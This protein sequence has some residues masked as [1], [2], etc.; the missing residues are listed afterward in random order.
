MMALKK[1]SDSLRRFLFYIICLNYSE[2]QHLQEDF[3]KERQARLEYETK[4]ENEKKSNSI[5]CVMCSLTQVLQAESARLRE[6]I[7]HLKEE[8]EK[9]AL[10]KE[11]LL[12]E[13]EEEFYTEKTNWEKK[14]AEFKLQMDE[15]ISTLSS[16]L[17]HLQQ[18]LDSKQQTLSKQNS[19]VRIA[20]I[21]S[22]ED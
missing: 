8:R 15:R 22:P 10:E 20:F 2:Y 13:K 1:G 12:K 9:D 11:R 14:Q 7:N 18:E 4:L 21:H 6:S 16:Q 3:D 19:L 17:E 5:F